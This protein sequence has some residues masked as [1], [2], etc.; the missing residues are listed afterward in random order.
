MC[1]FAFFVFVS[2][3]AVVEN[4]VINGFVR[5]SESKPVIGAVVS[6]VSLN[7]SAFLA[8]AITDSIGSFRFSISTE[9]TDSVWLYVSCVGYERQSQ[10][11]ESGEDIQITLH[12]VSHQ[13]QGV[14]VTAKSTVKGMPGG[15][16]FAPGGAEM[17]LPN[18]LELLKLTPMLDVRGGVSIFGKGDATVYINGRD[19]HMP[20]ESV[21]EM[22]RTVEPKEIKRIE[23][24]Y[25]PGSS[26]KA[27]DQRGIVNIVMK[28]P[29]YGW[30]GMASLGAVVEDDRVSET[31]AVYFGYGY[32]RFKFSVNA[33]LGDA[34]GVTKSENRYEYKNEKTDVTNMLWRKY[35]TISGG[36]NANATYD[37]TNKSQVGF[38]VSTS[39]LG[40][41]TWR[42][43]SVSLVDNSVGVV[44]HG[45]QTAESK[46]PYTFPS[47]S[48]VGFYSLQTDDRGSGLD[49]N[50]AYS[51]FKQESTD[52]VNISSDLGMPNWLSAPYEER[53]R[54]GR[55]RFGAEAKFTKKYAD[56][57]CIGL[58][59]AYDASHIDDATRFLDVVDD[60]CVD[61]VKT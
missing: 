4:R 35:K 60:I 54:Y 25:N 12:E 19:P 13:L 47:Y 45:I 48:F 8:N 23:I 11:I 59:G 46:T 1:L 2:V 58:G 26:L 51:R 22:L 21:F 10:G 39:L 49:L 7:D 44:R 31:P 6:C 38:S 3:K 37:I 32:G 24:I 53:S 40:G 41:N 36:A 5:D 42:E 56:G 52:N 18:G 14:T 17:L 28:R 34:R 55:H 61:N 30:V 43:T 29:D 9:N 15:F 57:S 33:R 16:S 20:V 27:S 50:L